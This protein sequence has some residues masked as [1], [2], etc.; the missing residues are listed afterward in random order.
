MGFVDIFKRFKNPRC[1]N[2][3]AD[4]I[5]GSLVEQFEIYPIEIWK[6]GHLY[7]CSRCSCYWFLPEHKQYTQRIHYS[8][9]PLA[10]H[11]NQTPLPLNSSTLS[12]LAK[13]GGVEGSK[14]CISIP[15]AVKNVSGGC[16]DKAVVLISKEPPCFWYEPPIVHWADEL[17]NINPSPFA[18]PLDVRKA[19]SR[20]ME[21]SMGFAPVGIV[22]RQGIE[23]TL[24]CESQF[25]DSN[26]VKGEEISLS[27]RKKKWK[28]TVL[29]SPAQVFYF[30]D[31]FDDCEEILLK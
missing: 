3:Q 22:D 16:H 20:K 12:V 30:V 11:W 18:L 26:D 5:H 14:N 9:L 29:P 25:F 23:Y 31:W 6:F 7:Q 8:L 19:S 21:V 4:F 1:K 17:A 15:C 24:P 28:K 27:R 13:I 10:H 2:C